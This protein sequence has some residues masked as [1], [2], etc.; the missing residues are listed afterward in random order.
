MRQELSFIKQGK[1]MLEF[2]KGRIKCIKPGR[3]L[4]EFKRQELSL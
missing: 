4:F 1:T 3:R 2:K